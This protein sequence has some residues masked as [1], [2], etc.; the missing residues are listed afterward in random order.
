[1]SAARATASVDLASRGAQEPALR[2]RPKISL[3]G[4]QVIGVAARAGDGCGLAT[5]DAAWILE[6]VCRAAS[7]LARAG[8]P[9]VVTLQVAARRLGD[10]TFAG[11]VLGT[12]AAAGLPAGLLELEV[13]ASAAASHAR[14]LGGLR[15]RGVRI[16]LAAGLTVSLGWA[17]LPIDAIKIDRAFLRCIEGDGRDRIMGA[18]T[19]LA[20]G[21]GVDLVAEGVEN[22]REVRRLTALG[23]MDVQG[24]LLARSMSGSELVAWLERRRRGLPASTRAPRS[25]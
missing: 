22:V 8:M 13:S 9:L 6:E 2:Y 15:A 25:P 11:D 17:R 10:P 3:R 24:C 19:S 23:M 18:I 16:V 21:L 14:V 4:A 5:Q 20:C 7:A 1:V 12:L